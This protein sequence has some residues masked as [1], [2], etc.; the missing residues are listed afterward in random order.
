MKVKDILYKNLTA[1]QLKAIKDWGMEND[2]LNA[3]NETLQD[4]CR[5][6]ELPNSMIGRYNKDIRNKPKPINDFD[7]EV[8]P[9]KQVVE[10]GTIKHYPLS[11]D[12][13]RIVKR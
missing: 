1:S 4:F 11:Q 13:T 7:G 9:V 10:K 6:H 12:E 3:I 2:I 5:F 8:I